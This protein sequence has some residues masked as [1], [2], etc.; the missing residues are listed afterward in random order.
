MDS[1][2]PP[3]NTHTE[4]GSSGFRTQLGQPP[5]GWSRSSGSQ[6]HSN[7][8]KQQLEPTHC[9]LRGRQLQIAQ[10][11]PSLASLRFP[12]PAPPKPGGSAQMASPR[13]LIRGPPSGMPEKTS[14]D[15]GS[16]S[17]RH[18]P[19]LP[20]KPISWFW[21]TRATWCLTLV[22]IPSLSCWPPLPQ[23]ERQP[24][25]D[26]LPLLAKQ[27]THRDTDFQQ[28]ARGYFHPRE[29]RECSSLVAPLP[30]QYNLHYGRRAHRRPG[31]QR[32]QGQGLP[33]ALGHILPAPWRKGKG[34]V[35]N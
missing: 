1:A 6:T 34:A 19:A 25:L 15:P 12:T 24:P 21:E 30:P 26:L 18:G 7:T 20:A 32:T 2:P 27:P 10:A 3:P 23:P 4:R 16:S 14:A 5:R 11:L 17:A 13:S 31:G 29:T 28:P 33:P 8:L 35:Q 9:V 22:Y